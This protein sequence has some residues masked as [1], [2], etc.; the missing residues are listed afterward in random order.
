MMRGVKNSKIAEY[1][2][3]SLCFRAHRKPQGRDIV[4]THDIKDELNLLEINC[5]L[6]NS[7]Y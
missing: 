1:L 5:L 6:P 4:K 2:Q 3:I 7:N